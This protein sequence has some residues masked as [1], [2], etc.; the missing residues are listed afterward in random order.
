MKGREYKLFKKLLSY[1][2]KYKIF[3]ILAPVAIAIEVLLEV[4][5]PF[6]MSIIVDC[7]IS[8]EPLTSKNN[9]IANILVNMGFAQKQG[10]DL[11]IAVG[12]VMLIMSL[13]SL[14]SGAG[15]A[16]FAAKAGMGFG[17]EL[18]QATFDKI[19]DF[20][21]KNIDKFLLV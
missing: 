14:L 19:Q 20:S 3:A 10:T 15:A 8:G 6:L 21:F 2:K 12:G 16:F 7:G 13:F 18:R 11:I 9:F 1:A 17:S 5:I 4:A